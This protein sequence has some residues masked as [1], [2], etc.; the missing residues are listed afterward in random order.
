MRGKRVVC[1]AGG[2]N[3]DARFKLSTSVA[4]SPSS[5]PL[6]RPSKRKRE[7]SA[8]FA[9]AGV[10]AS[11]YPPPSQSGR[12]GACAVALRCAASQRPHA[13]TS[14]PSR[15][16]STLIEWRAPR[17]VVT[18]GSRG[19]AWRVLADGRRAARRWHGDAAGS[20]E[21]ACRDGGGDG[22]HTRGW[23]VCASRVSQQSRLECR[24]GAYEV[25]CGSG[26]QWRA[27]HACESS[28]SIWRAFK[29]SPRPWPSGSKHRRRQH[30][31]VTLMLQRHLVQ[32]S[33]SGVGG[34]AR[35][36]ASETT[37]VRARLS[38]PRRQSGVA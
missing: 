5:P 6:S 33:S 31:C 19:C 35:R 13:T 16:G 21:G 15:C 24:S 22:R 20:H 18:A 32:F 4:N 38:S 37:L 29:S 36:A 17:G 34:Y 12:H 23:F 11:A 8:P 7:C 26:T 9:T 1:A 2:G 10:S 27:S 30:G 14:P 28:L 25:R 3:G